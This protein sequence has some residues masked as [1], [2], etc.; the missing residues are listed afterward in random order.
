M[1]LPHR[2]QGVN[3]SGGSFVFGNQDSIAGERVPPRLIP[4]ELLHA[5]LKQ[6][7]RLLKGAGVRVALLCGQEA[8]HEPVCT[9]ALVVRGQDV[10]TR[11]DGK[12]V[13]PI[14]FQVAHQ[15]F[16]RIFSE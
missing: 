15:F 13:V 14:D 7:K 1:L 10:R 3:A 2:Q 12:R 4:F 9:P 11:V 5:V 6:F 16:Q 8:L